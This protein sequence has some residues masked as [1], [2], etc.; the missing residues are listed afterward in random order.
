MPPFMLDNPSESE[1]EWEP[2]TSDINPRDHE[3]SDSDDEDESHHDRMSLD[4]GSESE[5]MAGDSTDSDDEPTVGDS[6][7]AAQ[8][9]EQPLA[10]GMGTKPQGRPRDSDALQVEE[11]IRHFERQHTVLSVDD[12][13]ETLLDE[14]GHPPRPG[15]HA[16]TPKA[17]QSSCFGRRQTEPLSDDEAMLF[18][19]NRNP[20]AHYKQGLQDSKRF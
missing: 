5:Y 14:V 12:D 17:G 3:V 6:L 8:E 18:D 9:L 15:T 20:P 4:S 7:E 1:L 10:P 16:G 13:S 2:V 11:E 19:G